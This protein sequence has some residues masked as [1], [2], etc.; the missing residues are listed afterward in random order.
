MDNKLN[1]MENR[2]SQRMAQL[3]LFV[4]E[5]IAFK[6]KELGF[7]ERGLGTYSHAGFRC[8]LDVPDDSMLWMNAGKTYHACIAP[9][10]QQA[11]VWLLS[12][13]NDDYYMLDLNKDGEWLLTKHNKETDEVEECFIDDAALDELIELIE[14]KR[15]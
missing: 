8:G 2:Y 4:P 3:K 1:Q 10:Y 14:L 7:N 15:K 6:L 11:F 13:L 5:R 9:L 12:E